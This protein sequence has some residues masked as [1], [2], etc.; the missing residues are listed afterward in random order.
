MA[1]A[2]L[3]ID[4]TSGVTDPIPV[5]IVPFA[6]TAGAS[7]G[8]D[9][10]QIIQND[11]E[12]CGRIKAMARS[13]MTATPSRAQDVQLPTWKAAGNDYVVVGQVTPL[14]AGQVVVEFELLNA[15]TGQQLA[16]PRFTGTPAALRDAAHR[17]SDVIYEK[18]LGVRGA[19]ATR[20]AYVSVDGQPPAQRYQLIV[21]DADGANP[22]V[23]LESHQPMMSPAW[24]PDGQWL[25]YVSFENKR[26]S[27]YVQQVSSGQR[28]QVSSRIGINGA[29]AWS[30]DGKKLLVTLGGSAGNAQS[31]YPGPGHTAADASDGGAG[32]RHRRGL[33]GRWTVRV[34][35]LRSFRRP[36]DLSH[37]RGGWRQAAAYHLWRLV[38][39]AAAAVA[40]WHPAGHGHSGWVQLPHCRAGSG[41]A[42]RCAFCP[43]GAWMPRRVSR[44]TAP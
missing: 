26:S 23:I 8:V 40:G 20:V 29:P 15:L 12:G 22:R 41:T 42:A 16:N 7:N 37:R 18:I 13:A 24:S 36:A 27:I 25:A 34:L 31:V 2:Q 6:N 10:A 38:Q 33:G 5:A 9:V 17:C 4:I 39:C 43:R 19:F 3:R 28:R 44:P 14:G 30:P 11:L 32:D 21:A 35:H 1:P